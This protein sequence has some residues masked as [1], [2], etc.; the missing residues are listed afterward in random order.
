MN[1]H[2]SCP[3][4]LFF[5]V[6]FF[7]LLPSL[8]N[9]FQYNLFCCTQKKRNEKKKII[10][11]YHSRFACETPST[12]GFHH[13][14]S[15]FFSFF[16]SVDIS[17]RLI[18]KILFAKCFLF[19]IIT[20]IFC[21]KK[22]FCSLN[23]IVDCIVHWTLNFFFF[24]FCF[25]SFE[26]YENSVCIAFFSVGFAF[27]FIVLAL[28]PSCLQYMKIIFANPFGSGRKKKHTKRRDDFWLAFAH[29]KKC[30]PVF[31]REMEK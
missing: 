7:L 21:D 14:F 16:C 18:L 20:K 28:S 4:R 2:I 27:L 13:R 12:H 11:A 10:L 9:R 17:F 8:G 30:L 6:Y 26:Y 5:F 23:V 1:T 19:A 15:F 3:C 25:Y 24:F 29:N 22:H 31:T